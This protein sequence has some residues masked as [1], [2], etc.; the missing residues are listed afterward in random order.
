MCAGRNAT[1]LA[2]VT[3]GDGAIIGAGTP[4]ELELL[5][6]RP[7]PASPTTSTRTRLGRHETAPSSRTGQFDLSMGGPP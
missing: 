6:W 2:G 3:I 7:R 1:I 4:A 5:A